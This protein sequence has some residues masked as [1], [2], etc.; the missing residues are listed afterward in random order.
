MILN[1]RDWLDHVLIVIKTIYGN[2]VTDRKDTVYSKY[3]TEL[4]WL[5]GSGMINDEN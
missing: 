3:E 4:L 1:Y 5:I 2:Y